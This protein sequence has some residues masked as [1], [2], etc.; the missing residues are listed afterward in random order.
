MYRWTRA[1]VLGN[2]LQRFVPNS[3]HD[4]ISLLQLIQALLPHAIFAHR[5]IRLAEEAVRAL[6][7]QHFLKQLWACSMGLKKGVYVGSINSKTLFKLMRRNFVEMRPCTIINDEYFSSNGIRGSRMAINSS[8]KRCSS[9]S[10][11]HYCI[12]HKAHVH[13]ESNVHVSSSWT[14]FAADALASGCSSNGLPY[15][16]VETRSSI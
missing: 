4:V 11:L 8:T 3:V 10:L 7:S 13:G 14:D 16:G 12:I 1:H 9:F 2:M 5:A 15:K 6:A